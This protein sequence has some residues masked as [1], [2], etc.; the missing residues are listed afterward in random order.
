MSNPFA[1]RFHA[2]SWE[3]PVAGVSLLLGVMISLG[4]INQQNR[5]ERSAGLDPDVA[6]RLNEGLIDV[7]EL[8]KLSQE[9]SKLQREK[10]KLENAMADSSKAT[11]VLN[12]G[13]QQAKLI[14]AL[15][16]VEGPGVTV[17]LRDSDRQ[18]ALDVDRIIHDRD[19]LQVVN[20]LW[21]SG[22]EA[23]EVNGHRVAGSTSF[24]CVGTVIQVDAVPIASPIVVRAIGDPDTLLGAMNLPGG[25]LDQLRAVDRAMVQIDRVSKHRFKAYGGNTTRRYLKVPKESK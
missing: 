24:R 3:W 15:T 20:E 17:T 12:D 11:K 1:N 14:A 2:N 9:V 18:D 13:L 10:T 23:V 4:W 16:D 5:T 21:A 7:N 25:I 19:V 6:K 8:Q 22:A